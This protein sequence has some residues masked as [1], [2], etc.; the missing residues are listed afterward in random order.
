MTA[1]AKATAAATQTEACMPS[2]KAPL[3]ASTNACPAS[4]IWEATATAPP[5]ESLAAAAA[6]GGSAPTRGVMTPA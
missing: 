3:A 6:S 4:P 1:P 5:I 2:M